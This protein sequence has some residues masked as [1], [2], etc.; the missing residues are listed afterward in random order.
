MQGSLPT[1]PRCACAVRPVPAEHGG[2]TRRSRMEDE[3]RERIGRL[4]T[5][6]RRLLAEVADLRN[7]VR[8]MRSP[9]VAATGSPPM[10]A[11]PVVEAAASPPIPPQPRPAPPPQT[12]I[13][14]VLDPP[15][16]AGPGPTVRPKPKARPGAG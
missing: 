5:A 14:R 13:Q 6:T 3:A 12:F 2:P 8:S 10:A 15:H 16:Q 4:E 7:E 1:R 9:S 11:T